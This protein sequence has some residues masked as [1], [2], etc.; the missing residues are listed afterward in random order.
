MLWALYTMDKELQYDLWQNLL[1]LYVNFLK[2]FS[3]ATENKEKNMGWE[4]ISPFSVQEVAN[5]SE[6]PWS[7]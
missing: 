2:T 5:S 7:C 4:K 1:Q 3:K 6:L